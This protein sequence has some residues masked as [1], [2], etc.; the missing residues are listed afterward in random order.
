MN[1]QGVDLIE[2]F[3]NLAPSDQIVEFSVDELCGNQS[4]RQTS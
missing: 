2:V 1:Y 3:G 4:E